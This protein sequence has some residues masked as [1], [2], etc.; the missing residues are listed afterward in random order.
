MKKFH[1]KFENMWES[2]VLEEIDYLINSRHERHLVE[3][4]SVQDLHEPEFEKH[5]FKRRWITRDKILRRYRRFEIIQSE[6][7][8]R[9]VHASSSSSVGTCSSSCTCDRFEVKQI[10][11]C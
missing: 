1:V 7:G 3:G 5:S 4:G 10:I 11:S 9:M 6:S 8:D 2:P